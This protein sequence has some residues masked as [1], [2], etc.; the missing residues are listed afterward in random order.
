M[1]KRGPP[2]AYRKNIPINVMAAADDFSAV[3]FNNWM[4][5]IVYVEGP[6]LLLQ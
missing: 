6:T 4:D 2:Y 5:T 1:M 3:S